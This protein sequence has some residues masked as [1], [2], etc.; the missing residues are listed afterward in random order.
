V[1]NDNYPAKCRNDEKHEPNE[2][3]EKAHLGPYLFVAE[4]A[5]ACIDHKSLRHSTQLHGCSHGFVINAGQASSFVLLLA[6]G[7]Q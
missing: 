5:T 6:S 7:R 3:P 4:L 2:Q 1:F